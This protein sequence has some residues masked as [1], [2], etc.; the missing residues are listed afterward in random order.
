MLAF[1][2]E[3][4]AERWCTGRGVPKGAVFP[5]AVLWRLAAAWYAGRLDPGWRR[6]TPAEAQA[7]FDGL[8]LTGAFWRLA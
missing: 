1:R 6:R 3:S 7:L 4:H 5:L 2:S 8:G